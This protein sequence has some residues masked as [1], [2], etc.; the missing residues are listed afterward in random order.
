MARNNGHCKPTPTMM[1][2][3]ADLSPETAEQA[4]QEN[5]DF[6][7]VSH[8]LDALKNEQRSS[9]RQDI[10]DH[11]LLDAAH[12]IEEQI[13]PPRCVIPGLLY[14]G[15]TLLVANPK[16]GKSLLV[17]MLLFR[18]ALHLNKDISGS[19]LYFALEDS[20][21]DL[22]QR[23]RNMLQGT[24]LGE[25][26]LFLAFQSR[27]VSDGLI[28]QL[29]RDLMLHPEISFVVLDTYAKIKP[30][31]GTSKDISA[32]DRDSLES[33]RDVAYKYH[34]AILI[35]HHTNKRIAH[36]DP[37]DKIA[38]TQQLRAVVDNTFM[39]VRTRGE[40]VGKLYTQGRKVQELDIDMTLDDFS[41]IWSSDFFE[42]TPEKESNVDAIVRVL[43]DTGTPLSPKEIGKRTAMNGGQVR[44]ILNRLLHKGRV[45][46]SSHGLWEL[47][48]MLLTTPQTGQ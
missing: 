19:G 46:N 35:V 1:N 2:Y 9:K 44:V 40:S 16:A 21:F 31:R 23:M 24:P 7:H 14:E 36:D 3:L 30:A 43:S 37:F 48:Q 47:S 20:R 11:E 22:Q 17:L 39:L 5:W 4:E 10:P 41:G 34:V 15:I 29:E 26:L 42:D 8:I 38:G 28:E 27:T 12:F 13:A 32:Y 18:L 6:Q 33:L 25:G 45:I